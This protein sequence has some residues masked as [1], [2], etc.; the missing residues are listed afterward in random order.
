MIVILLCG[1]V[2][3]LSSTRLKEAIPLLRVTKGVVGF[4]GEGVSASG[5]GPAPFKNN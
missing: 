2:L 3:L 1:Y 4:D 5:Y